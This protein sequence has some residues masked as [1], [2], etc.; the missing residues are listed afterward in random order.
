MITAITVMTTQPDSLLLFSVAGG[1]FPC[2]PRADG[3]GEG[4]DRRDTDRDRDSACERLHDGA[5]LLDRADAG[6]GAEA[7]SQDHVLPERNRLV[8][9]VEP[10]PPAKLGVEQQREPEEGEAKPKHDPEH[11]RQVRTALGQVETPGRGGFQ[12]S[13]SARLGWTNG[14]VE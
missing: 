7:A 12:P 14:D 2:S 4:D 10:A 1:S 8:G 9:Y 5:F 3:S 13:S 11:E 6:L